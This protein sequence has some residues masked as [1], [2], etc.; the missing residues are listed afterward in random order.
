[1]TDFEIL[2]ILLTIIQIIVIL[3]IDSI[4]NN[5]Q[6][7]FPEAVVDD[8]CPIAQRKQPLSPS[9]SLYVYFTFSACRCEIIYQ[10]TPH[11]AVT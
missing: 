10:T 4:K 1:M 3:L 11:I 7:T 2:A 6:P 9:I 8:Y 5:R